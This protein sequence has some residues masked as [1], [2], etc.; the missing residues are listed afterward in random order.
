MSFSGNVGLNILRIRKERG[1][2]QGDVATLMKG[3]GVPM[4]APILSRIENGAYSARNPIV[5]V[6]QLHAFSQALNVS[7]VDLMSPLTEL[8]SAPPLV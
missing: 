2:T 5:T 1:M 8:D 6:E 7:Y 4:S 3:S